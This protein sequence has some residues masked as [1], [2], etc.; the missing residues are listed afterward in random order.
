MNSSSIPQFYRDQLKSFDK[1]GIGNKTNSGVTVTKKLIEVT[2]KRLSQLNP[3]LG[4]RINTVS[5]CE[6]CKKELKSIKE[7]EKE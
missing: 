6:K 4:R 2:R 5:L 1:I 7:K 3:L